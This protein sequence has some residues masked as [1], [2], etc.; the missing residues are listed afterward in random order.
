MSNA[1]DSSVVPMVWVFTNAWDESKPRSTFSSVLGLV[2]TT[3]SVSRAVLAG[4]RADGL[5]TGYPLDQSVYDWAV[6]SGRFRVRNDRQREPKFQ[7]TFTSAQLP[8]AHFEKGATSSLPSTDDP[9]KYAADCP[10][11]AF[12]FFGYSRPGPSRLPSAVFTSQDRAISWLSSKQVSGMLVKCSV[13]RSPSEPP[14]C[15]EEV[16]VEN[17]RLVQ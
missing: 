8:H 16:R 3:A 6:Q 10:D 13:L 14:T 4:S 5:L 7:A 11:F 15:D 12:V 2:A 9:W 17:G 1:N